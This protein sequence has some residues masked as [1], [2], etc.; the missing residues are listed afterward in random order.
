[1]TG[2]AS[3]REKQSPTEPHH[4]T[5]LWDRDGVHFARDQTEHV[6]NHSEIEPNSDEIDKN[7]V[8]HE[9]TQVSESQL[10]TDLYENTGQSRCDQRDQSDDDNYDTISDENDGPSE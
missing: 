3:E 7:E 6:Y 4:N 5:S 2:A 8:P 10:H 1:M 9:S